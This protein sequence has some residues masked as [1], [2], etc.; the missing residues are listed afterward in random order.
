[1]IAIDCR[2]L[3]N[4]TGLD[5]Y[6]R[7]LLAA[8]AELGHA[9]QMVALISSSEQRQLLP[10]SVTAT[11]I[12]PKKVLLDHFRFRNY[13]ADPS[14][15]ALV[16][17]DNTAFLFDH[18]NSIVIL[19]DVMAWTHANV[20]LSTNTARHWRQRI[21]LAMQAR[22]L[23]N[24]KRIITVS[25]TSKK[26]ISS[27]LKATKKDFTNDFISVVPE[28]VDPL[29]STPPT[30][31]REE[32]LRAKPFSNYCFYVG[33]FEKNKNI[34]TL[35][36]AYDSS[37]YSGCL[38]LAGPLDSYEDSAAIKALVA[39]LRRKDSIHFV[40][41]LNQSDLN[42]YF[43]YADFFVYPAFE[44]GFG[45]PILEAMKAGCPV[46]CSGSGS[47]QEVGGNAAWYI[48]PHSIESLQV[49]LDKMSSLSESETANLKKS[50][51]KQAEAFDWPASAKQIWAI[52]QA[53]IHEKH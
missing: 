4:N 12:A 11:V 53:V 48:D 6:T 50:H 5:Y 40:G 30:Q 2:V 3:G 41:K 17:P 21:Y 43:H 22:A 29:F 7:D 9:Q 34:Q 13:V 26:E 49:A 46:I 23:A 8:L 35:L 47:F 14:I 24:V 27:V 36:K 28:S 1:M 18:A 32:F 44:G 25:N 31:S 37:K 16:H 38:V 20:V 33:G 15:K 51:L 19:H 52:I 39:S 42:S 10:N 45:R